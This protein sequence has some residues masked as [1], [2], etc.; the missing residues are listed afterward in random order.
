MNF[1]RITVFFNLIFVIIILYFFSY[2]N[3][4]YSGNISFYGNLLF[5]LPGTILYLIAEN[6]AFFDIKNTIYKKCQEIN[7]FYQK[8]AT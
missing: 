1:T 7:Y 8:L 5:T 2:V 4:S 6:I 3:N